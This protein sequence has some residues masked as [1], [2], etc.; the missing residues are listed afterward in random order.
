MLELELERSLQIPRISDNRSNRANLC[1]PNRRVWIPKLRVIED[2]ERL[3][4]ELE[5]HLLVDRERLE[6]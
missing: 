4:P 5:V 2:V 1:R 3:K 6:N